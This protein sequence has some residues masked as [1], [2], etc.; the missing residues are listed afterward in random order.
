MSQVYANILES[1]T[2]GLYNEINF[3]VREYLQNAYDAIKTAKK[4]G[5]PEPDEGYCINVQITKDNRIITITDNGIGM[6]ESVLSEYTSIGGG[7]KNDPDLT[8]HKGIGKLSG[9]RFFDKFIVKTKRY[10]SQLGYELVWD[11]GNMMRALLGDQEKMKK[12]PYV[13]FIKDFVHLN[14]FECTGGEKEHYTQIQLINVFD[15]F[16]SQ[17]NEM[18]IGSFIKTSSPVPFYAEGFKTSD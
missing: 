9:L 10:E 17:L 6:D 3:A 8:G 2:S 7:T 18:K 15:E 12:T 4:D 11:S 5:I 16:Q 13:D 1:L 14:R